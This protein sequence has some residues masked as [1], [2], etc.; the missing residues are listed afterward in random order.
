MRCG[1]LTIFATFNFQINFQKSLRAQSI[2]SLQKLTELE[3]KNRAIF[4]ANQEKDIQNT[5]L[6]RSVDG[7]KRTMKRFEEEYKKVRSEKVAAIKERNEAVENIDKNTAEL[8]HTK[9]EL[10]ERKLAYND[11]KQKLDNYKHQR[12]QYKAN[13]L[14]EE[15]KKIREKLG[16]YYNL[17]EAAKVSKNQI[18]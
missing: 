9:A 10:A 7:N 16:K 6:Q 3:D 18:I 14:A 1:V 15:N 12:E 2:D 5:S 4:I 17:Y 13:A 8:E 11:L